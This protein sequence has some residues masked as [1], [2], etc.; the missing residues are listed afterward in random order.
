MTKYNDKK[1][2]TPKFIEP[3]LAK[4]RGVHCQCQNHDHLLQSAIFKKY[5]KK[6]LVQRIEAM[7]G[8][9]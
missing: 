7:Y 9:K 2:L 1:C 8:R 4:L 5:S 3:A 6:A